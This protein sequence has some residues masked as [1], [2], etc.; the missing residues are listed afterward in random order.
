M[1][2]NIRFL[3]DYS[4]LLGSQETKIYHKGLIISCRN[5]EKAR[6]L[7][8]RGFVEVVNEEVVE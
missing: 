3:K 6:K 4:V 1:S 2:L 7:I 5:E 8:D